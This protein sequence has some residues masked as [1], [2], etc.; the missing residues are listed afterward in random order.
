[1]NDSI[2]LITI[3]IILLTILAYPLGLYIAECAGEKFN[4]F[5]IIERKIFAILKIDSEKAMTWRQY[6]SAV[7][8]FSFI[9]LLV[10]YFAQRFQFLFSG[11]PEVSPEISFNTAISFVTNTNWQTYAGE[12][13]FDTIFQMLFLGVQNFISASVGIAVLFVLIRGIRQ[14]ENGLLGNFWKDLIQVNLRILVPLSMFFSGILISQGVPQTLSNKVA[15]ISLEN[16]NIEIPLGMVASQEAIKQ[17]GTNGGGFFN[18]NSAHPFENPTPLTNF[19]EILMI[20]LVPAAL[21]FTYGKMINDQRQGISLY[22]AMTLIFLFF[23]GLGLYFEHQKIQV[24]L[25]VAVSNLEGKEVRN[26]IA[27]SVLWGIATTAASNGSV[28]AM[29]DSM[30]PM[31]GF[32][33]MLLMQMGE[34]VFGGVGSGLYGMLVYVFLTVFLAGLMIGKTPEYLGK[35]ISA[36]EIKMMAVILIVPVACVLFGTAIGVSSESLKSTIS[37]PAAHGF[38]QVLYAYSSMA[39]NNGSAFGGFGASHYFHAILGGVI[40]WLGRFIPIICVLA[41]AGSLAVKKKT[42][43]TLGTLPTH[44]PLFVTMLISVIMLFAA[45]TFIPALV[46]GPIAEHLIIQG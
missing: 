43:V 6:G 26:G 4:F 33:E 5:T 46:L 21:C 24:G 7:I 34:I 9:N 30:N 23:T 16:K 32:F 41:L 37:N 12:S 20:L 35:K 18:S 14:T 10:L 40:M 13:T 17:L 42:P 31:T 29:H 36:F 11:K 27:G 44:V 2:L 39:N 19:I 15:T 1:M 28:N 3:F 38:S 8:L 45:L 25:P 22:I